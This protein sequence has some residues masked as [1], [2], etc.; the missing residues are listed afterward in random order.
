VLCFIVLCCYDVLC[1]CSFG[2]LLLCCASIEFQL[3]ERLFVLLL[4]CSLSLFLFLSLFVCFLISSVVAAGLDGGRC[5]SHASVHQV[6]ARICNLKRSESFR[7][8]SGR[9][10]N[11]N[12]FLD[13][14][15][16]NKQNESCCCSECCFAARESNAGREQRRS[17]LRRRRKADAEDD[18][19][20]R[21]E[22]FSSFSL[23]AVFGPSGLYVESFARSDPC[24]GLC[25][26]GAPRSKQH[27]QLACCNEG[28]TEK[29]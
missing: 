5:S 2:C 28:K 13:C 27:A 12:R 20:A 25:E 29:R 14:C 16:Q 24:A 8:Q 19:A 1:W 11:R 21:L 22:R 26:A 9:R 10:T 18:S 23:D 7:V 3:V 17:R 15:K 4:L 6:F